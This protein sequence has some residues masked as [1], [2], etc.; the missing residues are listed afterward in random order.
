MHWPVGRAEEL[1]AAKQALVAQL[2]PTEH[3]GAGMAF[4]MRL[5]ATASPLAR[6]LPTGGNVVGVGVGA[7]T[8][9][10][11]VT[12]DLALRVYVRT[13]LARRDLDRGRLVPEDVG[14][15]PTDVVAVG[16]VV[17][18]DRPVRCGVS[19][20]H[21]DITAGTLG[22]LLR[23]DADEAVLIL[24]NNHVL[25][26]TNRAEI[27]DPILQPGPADG[28]RTPIARLTDFE[29]IELGGAANAFDAAIAAV[30][31][32]ADVEPEI[33][34]IG[35][36]RNPPA[37]A[38]L[39]QSVRKHGR[40][41][42]HTVGVVMDLSADLWVQLQPRQHAWFEDQLAV[43]GAGGDFSRPGD[44][45]ALVVDAVSRAPVGLLFAGGGDHTFVNPIQPVLD[46]FDATIVEGAVAR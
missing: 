30:I 17:A 20:G 27:G 26:N 42:R 35:S 18:F 23:R 33:E 9:A 25:A 21:P 45:G 16:D 43:I 37:D 29:P 1:R 19:V 7:K 32:P 4:G 24:S 22:C 44:S 12:A 8:T 6:R 5:A 46:R 40:T 34:G 10:G 28:G 13:K 3:G 39:Y 41:T 38:A 15:L 11:R 36:V 31:D 2:F 14:G